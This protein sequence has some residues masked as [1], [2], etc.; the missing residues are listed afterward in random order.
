MKG[1]STEE[2]WLAGRIK[3]FLVKHV[4]EIIQPDQW[5][6]G[7]VHSPI[8]EFL[9]PEFKPKVHWLAASG[10]NYYRADPFGIEKEGKLY[11]F[12]EEFNCK[13]NKGHISYFQLDGEDVLFGG[14]V[15]LNPSIHMSYPYLVQDGDNV[16]CIPE[17]ASKSE[18][19]LYRASHFPERW[20]PVCKI[21]DNFP[22]ID[23]T[24][25]FHEGRWWVACS[26]LHNWGHLYVW[27]ARCLLGPW[28][29]HVANPV[30][31]D[32]R[33]SRPAGTPFNRDGVLYRPAQDCS[34]TYGGQI[35]I[36]RIMELTPYAFREEAVA[37]VK[38]DQ[39]D[40]YPK[41]VHTLAALGGVTLLDGKR[42]VCSVAASIHVFLTKLRNI[43]YKMVNVHHSN[44]CP[45]GTPKP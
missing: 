28:R 5:N 23:P 38:P 6:I 43:R 33:S 24:A 19:G 34:S 12:F 16:Y 44:S 21:V 10:N 8:H 4:A 14:R 41:G 32:I 40:I 15:M 20:E 39:F 37:I 29:A 3:N 9:D 22:A 45:V 27:H 1:N 42:R 2:G 17:T 30:K 31:I 18:I 35:V 13:N 36:N 11:V 26:L 25:F 7:I